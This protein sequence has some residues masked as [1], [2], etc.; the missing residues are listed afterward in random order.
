MPTID[1]VLRA[2]RARIDATDAACLLAHVLDRSRGW[3]YAHGDDA[4]PGGTVEA[5]E[6]LVARC[7]DGEPV[8]YLTGTRG[9][10]R[11]DLAVDGA[12][13][14][15][16]AETERLVEAVL[17]RVPGDR[18][19]DVLDLGTGS[20]A[21]AL[22]VAHE[23]PR[24]NVFA[25]DASEGAL[26]VARR[27]ADAHGI[28]NVAFA[29]GDWWAAVGD[30]RFDVVASN[31]P[32][33]ADDDPHLHALRFEPRTALVSGCDGLDALRVIAA[34]AP[35]HLRPGGWLLVEHGWTQG[36]AVRALLSAAGL[37]AMETL[38]DLEGRERVTAGCL[39]GDGRASSSRPEEE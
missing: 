13:L 35:S 19:A 12:T 16:R 33:I 39:P 5:F 23:R 2:A 25:T 31:P 29:R 4:L 37:H 32:Y 17:A 27:N 21:I 7:A 34:G 10:W 22:A 30:R 3:L 15:P 8:A 11:L 20:G 6:H 18:P 36:A 14:V 38:P 1:H 24:A 9:F 26:A 28:R